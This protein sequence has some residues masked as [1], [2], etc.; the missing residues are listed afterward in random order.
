[1][2]A[3][4]SHVFQIHIRGSIAYII[5]VFDEAKCILYS[6]TNFILT[7]AMVRTVA[8]RQMKCSCLSA[9]GH[10]KLHIAGFFEADDHQLSETISSLDTPFRQYKASTSFN[11]FL[12]V[13]HEFVGG[14]VFDMNYW[15]LSWLWNVDFSKS[16]SSPLR[17]SAIY[18]AI[19]VEFCRENIGHTKN[20]HACPIT[21]RSSA[22]STGVR[23]AIKCQED[24]TWIEDRLVTC[25]SV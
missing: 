17:Y 13:S 11:S 1:M 16:S 3:T 10:S 21:I 4:L 7:F 6:T 14:Y 8:Q 25:G 18:Q 20:L 24:I 22:Q 23:R 12:C 5:A 15:K 2:G 9:M 19:F